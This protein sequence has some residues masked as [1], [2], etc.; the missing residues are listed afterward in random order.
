MKTT[1][2]S[3]SGNGKTVMATGVKQVNVQQQVTGP[4][5]GGKPIMQRQNQQPLVIGQLGKSFQHCF[6]TILI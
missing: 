6:Y 2:S 5:I 1:S 4:M 3:P